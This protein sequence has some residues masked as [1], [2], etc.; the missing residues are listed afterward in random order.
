MILHRY[1]IQFHRHIITICTIVLAMDL[2]E[3]KYK[4]WELELRFHEKEFA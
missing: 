3:Y 1:W 2:C 4:I